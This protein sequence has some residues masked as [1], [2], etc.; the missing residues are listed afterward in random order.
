MKEIE[1]KSIGKL[2][3]HPDIPDEWLISQPIAVPFL[4]NEEFEFTLVGDS[5]TDKRFLLEADEAIANFLKLNEDL[6]T[7]LSNYIYQNYQEVQEYYEQEP[8]AVPIL[9]LNN[10]DYIWNYVY[11]SE[12]Y[13]NRRARRDKDIYVEVHCGCEWEKEHGLQLVFRRGLKLTRVSDIDGHLTE[14]DAYDKPDSED[15]LLSEF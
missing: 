3:P 15:K 1:L 9:E 11:P 6:K 2:K 14:A 5:G 8:T 12:I 7:S 13:V 4:G 10:E